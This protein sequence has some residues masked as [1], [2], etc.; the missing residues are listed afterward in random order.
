MPT[1]TRRRIASDH[2]SRQAAR[3]TD[4]VARKPAHAD[5]PAG[6][7]HAVLELQRMAGN[8]AVS[9]L[10]SAR[11]G[12]ELRVQR[13]P[14]ADAVE[15]AIDHPGPSGVWDF[16][17]AWK[18]L[19]GLGTE[20]L[21]ETL[22]ELDGHGRLGQLL[23]HTDEM[24]GVDKARLLAAARAV[25]LSGSPANV[26]PDSIATTARQMET[27]PP[28]QQDQILQYMVGLKGA[29]PGVVATTMEGLAAI[30]GSLQ[31]S[32]QLPPHVLAGIKGPVGPGTW[33]PP[34][35]QN[36]GFY[37]G[38]EAHAGIAAEYVGAHPGDA[39]FTNRIAISTILLSVGIDPARVGAR[40]NFGLEPDIAN[41]TKRH[42]FEI[43][44]T[45][46]QAA[47]AA[48]V[49]A[50]A[51]LFAA[52][53]LPMTLGPMGEPGTAGAIPA[54]AGHYLFDTAEPGVIV[55]EYHRGQFAPVPVPATDKE[56]EDK[57]VT[58]RLPQLS[59]EQQRYI[60]NTTAATVM[61][62]ILVIILVAAAA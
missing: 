21:L 62:Y 28:A 42:L 33:A 35:K 25:D 55:Y 2:P 41:V 4:G 50:K 58:L 36:K 38:N 37:I 3:R 52:A 48:E 47:G 14:A 19:D 34:G 31:M 45:K 23:G 27:L 40:G 9:E 56:K 57:G 32:M 59:P 60:T 30:V 5:R 49:K 7:H 44:P 8:Q 43:K 13:S 29:S 16:K 24:E 1:Q 11:P 46:Y 17:S 20:Q 10:L 51:G 26:T 61:M 6:G 54:P 22:H 39:V 12:P 18:T 53:G 15:Q